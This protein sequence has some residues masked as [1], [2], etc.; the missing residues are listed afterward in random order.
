MENWQLW[1]LY[2]GWVST[3][4]YAFFSMS[5]LWDAIWDI[6]QNLD[7]ALKSHYN[8]YRTQENVIERLNT[9]EQQNILELKTILK[10]EENGRSS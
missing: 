8:L 6:Y 7:K 5:K 2:V 9:L 10:E 3:T 4:A 1:L